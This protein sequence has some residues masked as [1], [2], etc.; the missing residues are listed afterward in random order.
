MAARRNQS[1]PPVEKNGSIWKMLPCSEFLRSFLAFPCNCWP[2]EKPV[3]DSYRRAWRPAKLYYP[4]VP[5]VIMSFSSLICA[6][7]LLM[8]VISSIVMFST[9]ETMKGTVTRASV[10]VVGTK[11]LPICNLKWNGERTVV[12]MALLSQLSYHS[13][14]DDFSADMTQWF[15]SSLELQLP[16]RTSLAELLSSDFGESNSRDIG[17]LDFKPTDSTNTHIVV[18]RSNID[19]QLMVRD[20]QLWSESLLFSVLKIVVPLTRFWSDDLASDFVYTSGH[21]PNILGDR[22]GIDSATE[23]IRN[24][25]NSGKTVTVVGHGV[26]GGYARVLASLTDS[27]AVTFNAPGY[28]WMG[29]RIGADNNIHR[30]VSIS[31]EKD[32]FRNIDKQSGGQQ[33]IPCD[34]SIINCHELSHT[35]CSLTSSCGDSRSVS[36]C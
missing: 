4:R 25:R 30:E 14:A 33:T 35:V 12:D 31:S 5:K 32:A 2:I 10:G 11:R 34:E 27:E 8:F 20:L 17:L 13:D 1:I 19:G 26:N 3:R 23:Y 22:K 29:R 36:G 6:S 7:F 21:I 24:L 15:G 28:R 18:V 16:N 9:A